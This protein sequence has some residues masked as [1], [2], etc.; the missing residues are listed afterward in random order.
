M[1]LAL[2]RRLS[3]LALLA[4]CAAG[5][6]AAALPDG[7][8]VKGVGELIA[9]KM[10]PTY[11]SR[12]RYESRVMAVATAVNG[13]GHLGGFWLQ[14][15]GQ[16]RSHSLQIGTNPA[17]NFLDTPD[18]LTLTTSDVSCSLL[19][20]IILV[21]PHDNAY[22]IRV[23]PPLLPEDPVT[24]FSARI[25]PNDVALIA[26][27]LPLA[28][29]PGNFVAENAAGVVATTQVSAAAQFGEEVAG[30][31]GVA[32]VVGGEG[33][34][35]GGEDLGRL[36]ETAGGQGDVV[37]DDDVAGNHGFGDPVIGGVEAAADNLQG[38]PRIGGEAH[39]AVGDEGDGELVA[40][41][42]AIDLFLDRAGIGVDIDMQQ[43]VSFC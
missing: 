29:H 12:L 41:G 18:F 32:D 4:L 24:G 8:A 22:G 34:A 28:M 36:G 16:F 3:G 27:S 5:P 37:G 31:E 1:T 38:D 20:G 6:A 23:V 10:A 30:G 35:V 13:N 21:C 40:A 9:E 39:G 2:F 15:D 11:E 19:W 7:Y 33:F 25:T 26:D 42:D 43:R 17:L 14:N